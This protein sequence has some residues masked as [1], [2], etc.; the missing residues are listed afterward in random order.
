MLTQLLK[1]S[2]LLPTLYIFVA[3]NSVSCRI[4]GRSQPVELAPHLAMTKERVIKD[5]GATS[6]STATNLGNEAIF[7]DLFKD[8]E[9]LN[10]HTEELTAFFRYLTP[11]AFHVNYGS[12][13]FITDMTSR[14]RVILQYESLFLRR[15]SNDTTRIVD[16][17]LHDAGIHK[18]YVWT[19]NA[20][21]DQE[22][23][24]GR[25]PGDYWR[26]KAPPWA[27]K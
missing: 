2:F 15:F 4:V 7:I 20:L 19:G 25:F 24:S 5:V 8:K 10:A 14:S 13:V 6:Q 16:R 11:K 21:S 26:D 18:L 9:T 17:A 12:L 3:T 23:R 1:P 27:S 22:I